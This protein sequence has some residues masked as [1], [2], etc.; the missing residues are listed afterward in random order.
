M[1]SRLRDWP[2]AHGHQNNFRQSIITSDCP[3]TEEARTHSFYTCM[4]SEKRLLPR[5]SSW[6]KLI[7]QALSE[8]HWCPSSSER[9]IFIYYKFPSLLQTRSKMG[10]T[11]RLGGRPI[12]PNSE[13]LGRLITLPSIR[14]PQR[15]RRARIKTMRKSSFADVRVVRQ[16]VRHK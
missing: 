5:F 8:H 4:R 7:V 10:V 9:E 1:R 12:N 15:R 3:M 16:N 13:T 6:T 11:N 14:G 2:S